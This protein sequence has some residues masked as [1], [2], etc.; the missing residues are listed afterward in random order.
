MPF[1]G[2]T[3]AKKLQ[4]LFL[5]SREIIHAYGWNYFFYVV[6]LEFKIQKFSMF[7]PDKSPQ[8]S[9]LHE[10]YQNEY[11]IFLKNQHQDLLKESSK[12]PTSLFN[13]KIIIL[14]HGNFK[15]LIATINSLQTQHYKNWTGTILPTSLISSKDLVKINDY[16]N[17]VKIYFS[18]ND[19]KFIDKIKN[20]FDDLFCILNAG[21]VLDE[22]ALS[23]SISYLNHNDTDIVYS[24]HDIIDNNIR[25]YPFFKP[26]WSPYLFKSMDFL[27][28]FCLIKAEIFNKIS[29]DFK[30]LNCIQYDILL[31]CTELTNKILHI[32]LPLCSVP[33]NSQNSTFCNK[34]ILKNH[35]NRKNIQATVENGLVK[36]TNKINYK[37]NSKPKVSIF[38]PTRNNLK[39]IKRCIQ[40]IEKK[41]NYLNIEIIIIDN[42]SDKP[43][44]KKYYETLSYK[45]INYEANF[46]FSKMN[47]LA[48]KHS[49]GDLLLFLNDD[50]KILDSNWL[51][52]LVSICMQND[53]GAVGPKLIFSDDTIQ[54]A[55]MV[56]LTTGA[57]FHPG[58]MLKITT[59]AHHN[60]LNVMRDYSALTGACLMVKKEIFE[61]VNGFDDQF[62]VYYGDSD[63]CLKI[64]GAGFRVVYTPFTKLLH[65]G[66]NS[67]SAT[68][69]GT[70]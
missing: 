65:E 14:F 50:T 57:G 54:H 60:M 18:E 9:F 21:D 17:I 20:D 39:M 32:S 70:S 67:I 44:L 16:Q 36:N 31:K 61:K 66:S 34:L 40:S 43:K 47:N 25:K 56:F 5:L 37:L 13:V 62:D 23:K 26:D 38:I 30:F 12:I 59:T 27:S 4:K 51:N 63:L 7:T 8:P 52:E 45:I 10:N 53:I 33:E 41:T 3:R 22:F 55:G 1:V 69:E 15:K 42:N 19:D 28:P 6:K 49:T 35:L 24:D 29:L 46:N 68:A 48:V 64:I 58:M 2:D 11:D